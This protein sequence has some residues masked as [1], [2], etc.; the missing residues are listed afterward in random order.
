MADL[1][2]IK[3]IGEDLIPIFKELFALV[4]TDADK[5]NKDP[6]NAVI[7]RLEKVIDE[8]NQPTKATL[9]DR[10]EAIVATRGALTEILIQYAS[11]NQGLPEITLRIIQT[12]RNSLRDAFGRLLEGTVFDPIPQ[13][14]SKKQLEQISTQLE[15]A[16]SE[17]AERQKAKKILET[18]VNIAI[19]VGKI[20]LTLA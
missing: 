6:E 2:D 10:V 5:T 14:L 8:S 13:L 16:T 19:T 17:I 20:A 1:G 15:K 4:K 18:T 12:Q 11:S 7:R 9:A 3:K